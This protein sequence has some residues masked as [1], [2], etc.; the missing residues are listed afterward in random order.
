MT[1]LCGAFDSCVRLQVEVPVSRIRDE[2]V[3]HSSGLRITLFR[4]ANGC[5]ASWVEASIV[6]RARIVSKVVLIRQ[7]NKQ[8]GRIEPE[9]GADF[10]GYKSDE[11]LAVRDLP[12]PTHD[13]R[14]LGVQFRQ[15]HFTLEHFAATFHCCQLMLEYLIV[16]ALIYY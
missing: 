3:D 12:F 2:A 6:P 15:F 16:L 4:I 8:R 10:H 7:G 13:Q 9:K 1:W 5:L 14:E 11:G